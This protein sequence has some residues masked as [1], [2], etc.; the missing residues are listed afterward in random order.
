MVYVLT[1]AF[2]LL[3]PA[4]NYVA[5]SDA[6]G[7]SPSILAAGLAAD[8]VICAVY[9]TTLFALA[10][11]IPPENPSSTSGA[12]T[13]PLCTC[14]FSC[15]SSDLCVIINPLIY[16]KIDDSSLFPMS[17]NV[18]GDLN[19]E[20]GNS[21]K[22]PVIQSATAIAI[23]LAICKAGAFL[24]KYF[25]KQ[26]GSL[27][28]ITAIVVILATL[29]PGQFNQIAPPGEALALILMQVSTYLLHSIFLLISDA[30]DF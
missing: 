26:G 6:L 1:I 19:T 28:A 21:T 11:K 29:F 27:P 25:G 22:L 13:M 12:C 20:S 18:D 23:S 14:L 3:Q 17:I 7:V 2:P 5:I 4:V 10:S 9:F 24:T 30:A 8:N 16:I 15:K